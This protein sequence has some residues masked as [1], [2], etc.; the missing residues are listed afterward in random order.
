ME[1]LDAVKTVLTFVL[2]FAFVIALAYMTT[3]LV[4]FTNI[5]KCKTKNMKIVEG[6]SVGPQKSLQ[7]VKVADKVVL[8]AISKDNISKIETFDAKDINVDEEI[9]NES[10][11]VFDGI[12]KKAI[13]DNNDLDE[14]FPNE[15][16]SNEKNLNEDKEDKVNRKVKKNR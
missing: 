9:R 8:I 2:S 15:K 3:K 13:D 10:L 16:F 5:K 1:T 14:K 12:F 6:I 4:V 11:N 7:L